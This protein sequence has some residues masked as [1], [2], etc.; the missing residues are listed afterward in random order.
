MCINYYYLLNELESI[1]LECFDVKK[2]VF[3][4]QPIIY[5]NYWNYW[6]LFELLGLLEELELSE[7]LPSF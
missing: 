2:F 5:W 7:L 4:G 6:G 3:R 1:I